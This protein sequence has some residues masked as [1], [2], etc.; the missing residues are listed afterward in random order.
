M[1]LQQ[2]NVLNTQKELR[3]EKKSDNSHC[4]SVSSGFS[5]W[6]PME[7]FIFSISLRAYKMHQSINE[8]KNMEIKNIYVH[9]VWVVKFSH[10]L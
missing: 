4:N 5:F 10:R 9:K 1:N 7:S 3:N 6:A 8:I 2:R